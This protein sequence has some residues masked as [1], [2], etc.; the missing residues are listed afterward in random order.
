MLDSELLNL[1]IYCMVYI[2]K[3]APWLNAW[4]CNIQTTVTTMLI[5]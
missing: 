5:N 3:E 1:L 2:H 4:H